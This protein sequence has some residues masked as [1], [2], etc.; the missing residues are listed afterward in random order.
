MNVIREN[1]G[2]SSNDT[3][4]DNNLLGHII[5][6]D[7][8]D[9]MEKVAIHKANQAQANKAEL[10]ISPS[11]PGGYSIVNDDK[12]LTFAKAGRPSFSNP[13][14]LLITN[15]DERALLR[16]SLSDQ[17]NL[18]FLR[19][20]IIPNEDIMFTMSEMGINRVALTP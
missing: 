15:E 6:R 16:A 19:Y 11:T 14:K 10:K 9:E 5:T 7:Q 17:K 12:G 20:F 1:F 3:G 2:N 13:K 4:P 18:R 8:V